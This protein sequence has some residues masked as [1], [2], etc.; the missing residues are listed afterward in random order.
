MGAAKRREKMLH[1]LLELTPEVTDDFLDTIHT[2]AGLNI[3]AITPEEIA[4]SITAEILSVMRNKEVFSL[5]K[6]SGGIHTN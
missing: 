1:E 2:P 6:I 4:M 5:K 3:G